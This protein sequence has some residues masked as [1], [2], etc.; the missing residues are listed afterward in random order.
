M[1][2]LISKFLDYSYNE[3]PSYYY[4]NPDSVDVNAIV[5]TLKKVF[6]MGDGD[7]FKA[8][9]DWA[10]THPEIMFSTI[11]G[12]LNSTDRE[13]LIYAFDLPESILMRKCN[14]KPNGNEK[15]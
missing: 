8:I 9:L 6:S 13:R 2:R 15:S 3:L 14:Y 1:L 12:P 5:H 11:Y 10:Q 7:L 4:D